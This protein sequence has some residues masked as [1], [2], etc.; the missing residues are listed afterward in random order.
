VETQRSL[1]FMQES[2]LTK[3]L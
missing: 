1:T 3:D 2:N